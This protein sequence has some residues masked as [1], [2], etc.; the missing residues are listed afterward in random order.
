MASTSR[1]AQENIAQKTWEM[2][3][4]V[5]MYSTLDDIYKYDKRMQQEILKAEPWKNEYV[6]VIIFLILYLTKNVCKV[7]SVNAF[8]FF[9]WLYHHSSSHQ[10]IHFSLYDLKNT[11]KCCTKT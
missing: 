4:N 6:I 7:W 9:L 10:L 2:E 8:F 3:N 1:D 5:Q 11:Y